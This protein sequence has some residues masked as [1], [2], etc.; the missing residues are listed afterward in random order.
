MGGQKVPLRLP[1]MLIR[2][3]RSRWNTEGC[4]RKDRFSN[5]TQ[6]QDL[7]PLLNL[8]DEQLT[9]A[10][11]VWASRSET[12][13]DFQEASREPLY[14]LSAR[15]MSRMNTADAGVKTHWRRCTILI[16]AFVF[17]ADQTIDPKSV[18]RHKC[19]T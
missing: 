7:M 3:S 13:R 19:L 11:S 18:L 6:T 4:E 12:A 9:E 1:L 8:T 15:Q 14:S 16:V 10:M 2:Q 5:D 17:P